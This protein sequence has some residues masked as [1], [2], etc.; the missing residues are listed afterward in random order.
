[1]LEEACWLCLQVRLHRQEVD[2][3]G[4]TLLQGIILGLARRGK[5]S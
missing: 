4:L 2:I 5:R 3:R 1:M